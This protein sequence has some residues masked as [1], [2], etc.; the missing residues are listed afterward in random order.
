MDAK[1]FH[2]R[3]S[4]PEF[5]DEGY[6]GKTPNLIK[7]E[8]LIRE[9]KMDVIGVDEVR[10]IEDFKYHM[11]MHLKNIANH[12]NWKRI[13]DRLTQEFG[14][15]RVSLFI[16]AHTIS[17]N[18]PEAATIVPVRSILTRAILTKVPLQ[19]TKHGELYRDDGSML[20]TISI[21]SQLFFI[22]KPDELLAVLLHEVGHNF[23]IMNSSHCAEWFGWVFGFIREAENLDSDIKNFGILRASGDTFFMKFVH[24]VKN[25]KL[26]RIINQFISIYKE[27]DKLKEMTYLIRFFNGYV[28][29]AYQRVSSISTLQLAFLISKKTITGY[30]RE[31]WSDSFATAYGYGPSLISA[32][33]KISERS[34][35]ISTGNLSI[36]NNV[37]YIY[38]ILTLIPAMILDENQHEQTRIKDIIASL[39]RVS[40]DPAIPE[41]QRKCIQR[42]IEI[43][44]KE[45]DLYVRGYDSDGRRSIIMAFFRYI[46]DIVFDGKIDFRTYLFKLN[47]IDPPQ[48]ESLELKIANWLRANVKENSIIKALKYLVK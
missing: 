23:D 18:N 38:S 30:S 15:S 46:I 47:A 36:F 5:V 4:K 6:V 34:N 14:F 33:K 8:E 29:H 3:Y 41:F 48:E 22:L 27:V 40:K 16:N 7:I 43:A 20:L 2:Q 21:T 12:K 45:Y 31:F 26:G 24:L 32:L 25:T 39:E 28:K 1:A 13:E 19:N 11:T 37:S 35:F 44:K 9:I 17:V 42:D 10:G